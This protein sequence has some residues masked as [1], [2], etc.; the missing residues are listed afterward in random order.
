MGGLGAGMG[1]REVTADRAIAQ[2][3]AL[4]MEGKLSLSCV[5]THASADGS[6]AHR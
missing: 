6:D 3:E 1:E 2:G 4:I 5:N